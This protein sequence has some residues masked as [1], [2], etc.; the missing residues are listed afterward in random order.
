MRKKQTLSTLTPVIWMT[1]YPYRNTAGNQC[2]RPQCYCCCGKQ[3]VK[4]SPQDTD[5]DTWYKIIGVLCITGKIP[6]P[7]WKT[8]H[9]HS[10]CANGWCWFHW[11]V[12]QITTRISVH[13]SSMCHTTR[14][15][16]SIFHYIHMWIRVEVPHE[17]VSS[18]EHLSWYHIDCVSAWNWSLCCQRLFQSF[19]DP[20]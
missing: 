19:G 5:T 8:S 16:W 7:Q 4:E 18:Q 2:F 13:T 6:V 11:P 15:C 1:N 10:A 17:T 9:W 3:D 12:G 20:T 14:M